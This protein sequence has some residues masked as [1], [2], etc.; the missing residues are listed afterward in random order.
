MKVDVTQY[1]FM[2]EVYDLDGY[3]TCHLYFRTEFEAVTFALDLPDDC[4]TKIVPL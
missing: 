4:I 2:L 3:L 1:C